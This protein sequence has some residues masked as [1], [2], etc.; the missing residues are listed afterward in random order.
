[1]IDTARKFEIKI[2]I[3]QVTLVL[4]VLKLFDAITWSWWW[5]LS[6]IWA[7]YG[8]AIALAVIFGILAAINEWNDNNVR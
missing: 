6:P 8:A 5:V 7:F 4:V 1:M 2:N 3:F